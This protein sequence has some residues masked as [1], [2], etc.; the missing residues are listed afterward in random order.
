MEN[1]KLQQD[2]IAAYDELA[3]VL[4][5]RFYFKLSRRERAKDLVQETF[6][7]VWQYIR[8]GKEVTN[9]RAF[10]YKV[11]NNLIIDEYRR[12]KPVSL[13]TLAENGFDVESKEGDDKILIYAE[14]EHV[15]KQIDKL[16]HKYREVILLRYIEG[17]S[18]KKIGEIVGQTENT[19]SVRINRGIKKLQ[20]GMHAKALKS[21][22]APTKEKEEGEAQ[23]KLNNSIRFGTA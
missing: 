12:K 22:K 16:P 2:F 6:T 1:Y 17:L 14:T 8:E 23:F 11:A 19:V 13:D 9:L 5:R 18:P 7:R 10:I 20:E 21:I 15:L 3:D 4:F